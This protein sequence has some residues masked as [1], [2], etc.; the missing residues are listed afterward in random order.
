L[1]KNELNV[2]VN[3]YNFQKK[4]IYPENFIVEKVEFK[5]LTFFYHENN[6]ILQNFNKTI[7]KNSIVGVVG[8]TGVGKTTLMHLLSGIINPSEGEIIINN[9]MTLKNLENWSDKIAYVSQKPF[10]IDSTI[11]DNVQLGEE[12]QNYNHKRLSEAYSESELDEFIN[13]LDNKDLSTVGDAGNLISGGQIQ[14]IGIARALY[15]KADIFLLDEITSN[16]DSHTADSIL[17]FNKAKK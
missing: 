10:I 12:K 4:N 2:K 13:K 1:I 11:R 9:N 5:N 3:N 7:Y 15:K 6:K 17:K 14:R 8:K 16:L